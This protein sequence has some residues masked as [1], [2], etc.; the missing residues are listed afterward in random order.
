MFQSRQSSLRQLMQ[1]LHEERVTPDARLRTFFADLGENA[2]SNAMPVGE[3][4]RR[5]AVSL[6]TLASL[7]PKILNYPEDI[8]S[9]AE[10]VFRYAGYVAR[11]QEAAKRM[12]GAEN[13]ALPQD[14]DY[15]GIAGLSAEAKEKLNAIKPRTLGQAARIP[16]ITPAALACIEVQLKKREMNPEP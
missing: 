13:T 6:E 11:Q 5:P 3:L 8:R 4:F 12:A 16:G 2:P 14:M 7:W 1:D 15:T 9:E 10:T